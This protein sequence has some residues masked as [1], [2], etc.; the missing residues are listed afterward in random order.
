MG[1]ATEQC[2]S[3]EDFQSNQNC[4]VH[5]QQHVFTVCSPVET[6]LKVGS[7]SS[8]FRDMVEIIG[9]RLTTLDSFTSLEKY[10]IC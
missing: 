2:D 10:K 3:I 9:T 8:D 5:Q 4:H 7:K 6:L 1:L